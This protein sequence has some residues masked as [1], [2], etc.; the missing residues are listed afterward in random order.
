MRRAT[1][2]AIVL[3]AGLGA[4]APIPAPEAAPEEASART[5]LT[6]TATVLAVDPEARTL[7]LRDARTGR[8]FTVTADAEAGDLRAITPGD[9]I[10][11]EY[12]ASLSLAPAPPDD[13][14]MPVA[15]AE[16]APTPVGEGPGGVAAEATSVVVEFLS[17]DPLTSEAALRGPD[18][19]VRRLGLAPPLTD[20]VRGLA[21]GERVLVTLTEVVAL[22]VTPA[23]G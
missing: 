13:P 2:F 5:M 4:C 16:E 3:A 12:F 20:F 1:A 19:V 18:G 23:D 9:V 17:F 21:P 11:L 22:S 10:M 15:V 6:T 14:G 7:R 8:A